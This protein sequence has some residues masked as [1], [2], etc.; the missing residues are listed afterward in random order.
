MA[1]M[2]QYSFSIIQA[3]LIIFS[4]ISF[5]LGCALLYLRLQKMRDSRIYCEGDQPVRHYACRRKVGAAYIAMAIIAAVVVFLNPSAGSNLLY[6]FRG[7]ALASVNILFTTAVLLTLIY[8]SRKAFR[9]LMVE[10]VLLAALLL[11]SESITLTAE[12]LCSIWTVVAAVT[13]VADIIIYIRA[14]Q[15]FLRTMFGIMGDEAIDYRMARMKYMLIPSILLSLWASLACFIPAAACLS[16]I[17]I[18]LSMYYIALNFYYRHHSYDIAVVEEVM[19]QEFDWK[20]ASDRHW[21]KIVRDN[22]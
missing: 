13:F 16:A 20:N 8:A 7:L 1:D 12:S 15:R 2:F 18:C 21:R 5:G 22:K 17:I 4:I 10:G 19:I 6:P 11:V 9:I 3:E 14:R